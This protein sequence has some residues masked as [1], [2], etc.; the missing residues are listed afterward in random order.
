[1]I[2]NKIG[3]NS[4]CWCG[5]GK[6][7][8]KCH[9]NRL[10]EKP[11]NAW[12]AADAMQKNFSR[13]ICSAPKELHDECSSLIVKAHTVPKSMSLNAISHN[14]HVLGLKMNLENIAKNNG[15][16]KPELIGINKAST[17]TGFCQKHDDSFFACLEKERFQC[18]DE[19]C[20]KLAYRSF[21]REAYTKSALVD[22]FEVNRTLDKGKSIDKQMEIQEIA[23]LN[24][25]GA[26]AGHRDNQFHKEKF[27][28]YIT[29]SDY[30]TVRAVAFEFLD[31]FPIQ[32]C[33]SVNPDYDF[34]N[35]RIQ[36]LMDFEVVPDLLSFTSFYDGEKSYMVFVWLDY[37]DNSCDLLIKSLLS[38]PKSDLPKLL[39]QFIF[40][41]FENFYISPMWWNGISYIEQNKIIEISQENSSVFN[42]PHGKSISSK[43]LEVNLPNIDKINFVNC[44]FIL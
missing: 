35:K 5:S 38:K 44:R 34:N 10:N 42:E 16:L 40:S 43:L 23:F 11:V 1:M 37:C 14:G 17:F 6:K 27:D 32:A 25:I 18:T 2:N 33:G 28:N 13:K 9:L 22:M 36:D 29:T 7:Y 26:A 21:S 12:D 30:S 15:V 19:Q 41:S 24:H 8:K 39:S 20:F 4:P 31:T 3:R